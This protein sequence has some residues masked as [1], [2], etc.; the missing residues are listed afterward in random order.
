M[1]DVNIKLES[2]HGGVFYAGEVMSGEATQFWKYFE[3]INS[4]FVT[5]AQLKL[6]CHNQQSSEVS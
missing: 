4:V 6:I 3:T 1:V 5:Q 2:Q